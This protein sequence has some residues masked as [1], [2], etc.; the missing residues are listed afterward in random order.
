MSITFCHKTKTV[1]RRPNIVHTKLR[2]LIGIAARSSSCPLHA[3]GFGKNCTAELFYLSWSYI[4]RKTKNSNNY[5]MHLTYGLIFWSSKETR[6]F[7]GIIPHPSPLN[8]F[9]DEDAS[10][11]MIVNLT[12]EPFC[13]HF[14][15]LNNLVFH[16]KTFAPYTSSYWTTLYGLPS[17]PT[18]ICLQPP[19]NP[20]NL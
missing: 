12:K 13:L 14:E 6:N 4:S 1:T 15:W 2:R 17:R 3:R 9:E 5:I 19:V 20:C 7:M 8:Q 10:V 18:I 16:I 11:T